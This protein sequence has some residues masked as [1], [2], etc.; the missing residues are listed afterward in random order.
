MSRGPYS[1]EQMIALHSFF[2]EAAVAGEAAL[3]DLSGADTTVDVVEVRAGSLEQ[4][5]ERG[6]RIGDDLAA[7]VIGRLEGGVSGTAC[8]VLDPEEALAWARTG[9]GA[10]PIATFVSLGRAVDEGLATALGE[11]TRVKTTFQAARLVEETEPCLLASTHAPA[12]TIV[13]SSRM[14]IET[15]GESFSAICHLLTEP[16]HAGRLLSC[17]AAPIH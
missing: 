16:K 5:G 6:M 10:D 9:S 3:A 15:R 12:D 1:T 13:L 17:L 14:R 7:A 2:A 8:L 4:F 11:A